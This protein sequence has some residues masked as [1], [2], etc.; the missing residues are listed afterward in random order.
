MIDWQRIAEL[1]DEVGE[2][3]FEEIASLFLEEVDGAMASLDQGAPAAK[4]SDDLHFLKGCALNLGF[5]ALGNLCRDGERAAQEG[6]LDDID[7]AAVKSV[8]AES[9]AMFTSKTGEAAA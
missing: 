9:R 7:I 6:R 8:Y 2:E 5:E 1:R 3:D 4:M